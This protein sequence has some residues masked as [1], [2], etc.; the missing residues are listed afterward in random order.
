M[1][2]TGMVKRLKE[3][4]ITSKKELWRI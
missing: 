4:E 1:I 2:E 3:D